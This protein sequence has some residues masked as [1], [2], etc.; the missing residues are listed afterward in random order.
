M[1]YTHEQL[2]LA[3]DAIECIKA[4]KPAEQRC[5][6]IHEGKWHDFVGVFSLAGKW[7]YRPKPEPKT[8]PWQSP[9]D[10]P[11]NCWIR[12]QYWP[13]DSYLITRIESDG[14]WTTA[15]NGLF[16]CVVCSGF[17]T[18]RKLLGLSCPQES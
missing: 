12:S 1:K 7:E 6:D 13:N 18:D 14:F 3:A 16:M 8:R 15:G 2:R 10:V 9:E 4:G 11:L 17:A 5:D